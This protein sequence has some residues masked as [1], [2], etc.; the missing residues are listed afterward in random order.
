MG[1]NKKMVV[2]ESYNKHCSRLKDKSLYR[3]LEY[4]DNFNCILDFSSN[5]YL[6]LSRHE[7]VIEH[8]QHYARL[9]GVG[10][11]SSRLLNCERDFYEQIES[12]VA[13]SKQ[14]QAS[15]IF[16]S[17]YQANS[18]V[19]AAML[20]RRILR[21]SPL[22]FT[23][24][25]NHA[26]LHHGCKLAGV[27]QHRFQHLDMN[28]LAS[29]LNVYKNSSRPKFII[30]E[31]IFSMDGDVADLQALTT[32]AEQHGAF[33]YVDE[34]H[35]TGVL[36]KDGYGLTPAYGEGVHMTMGTFSKALGS[37][38]A[39]VACSKL[40]K[41]YL[42]NTC[43]GFIY[44]TALSPMLI[45]AIEAAWNLLPSLDNKRSHLLKLANALRKSLN[46]KG[47]NTGLSSTQIVP[48]LLKD[49]KKTL[50]AQT[51]L[52]QKNIQ[53]AAIRPPTVPSAGARLRISL[54]ADH[55]LE[56]IHTL[57]ENLQECL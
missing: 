30:T 41:D 52:A 18:T 34:A 17:G 45:G 32:L 11:K 7:Q 46:D 49:V 15:L 51:F 23:D 54:H 47:F 13:V 14:K 28:H 33:L 55:T 8:A 57:V 40:L 44:S 50:Q 21:G 10:G 38:G 42:V 43:S 4:T 56:N 36:G 3:T 9:Y 24:R 20:D 39:Y 25:L 53:V 22:V 2:L 26:S 27:Q 31:S 12:K 19:L 48:I 37:A 6:G 1:I 35:A 16:N 29:L 5:D